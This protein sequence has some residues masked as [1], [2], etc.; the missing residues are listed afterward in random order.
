MELPHRPVSG[1]PHMPDLAFKRCRVITFWQNAQL[2]QQEF[3]DFD[4]G[5]RTCKTV[6]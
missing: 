3:A 5:Q 4:G 6:K 2:A 1:A